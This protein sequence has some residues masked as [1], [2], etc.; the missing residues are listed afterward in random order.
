[1]FWFIDDPVIFILVMLCV[2]G[3]CLCLCNALWIW[4]W[5][6]TP[7]RFAL[8]KFVVWDASVDLILKCPCCWSHFVFVVVGVVVVVVVPSLLSLSVVHLYLL[9]MG[10]FFLKQVQVGNVGWEF[11]HGWRISFFVL[12]TLFV[13]FVC[14]SL[15]VHSFH[16]VDSFCLFCMCSLF[17]C[18]SQ[19]R[20]GGS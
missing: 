18:L 14:F 3:L 9:V 8:Y 19:C 11:V 2:C 13:G 1:M 4:L 10:A 15:E 12:G 20:V 7:L 6:W 16:G 5:T 17:Y